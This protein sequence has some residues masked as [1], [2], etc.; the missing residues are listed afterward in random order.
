LYQSGRQAEDRPRVA[1]AERADDEVVDGPGAF[2]TDA[3]VLALA[4]DVAERGD[5][6]GGVAHRSQSR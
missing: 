5:G 1:G 3:H 6:G 4:T 2:S